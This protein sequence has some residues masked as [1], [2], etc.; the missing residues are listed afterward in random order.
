MAPNQTYFEFQVEQPV[1]PAPGTSMARYPDL[2]RTAGVEGEVL[3]EFVVGEDGAADVGSFKVLK[4]TH[5]SF[6]NAVREALPR[7]RFNPARVGGKAVRQLVQQ[8]FTFSITK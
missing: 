6:T 5:P 8:P 7:T 3:A 4:S 1:T 2:M